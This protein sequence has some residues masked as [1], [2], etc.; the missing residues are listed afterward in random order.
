MTYIRK[1]WGLIITMLMVMVMTV[2]SVMPLMADET[3]EYVTREYAV[4]EFVQSAGRNNLQGS[5]LVLTLFGDADKI[6]PEY[7]DDMAKAITNGMVTGSEDRMLEPAELLKRAEALVLFER[8]ISLPVN[9]DEVGMLDGINPADVD[10]AKELLPA[11]TPEWAVNEIAL[12]VAAGL[13]DSEELAKAPLT[14]PVTAEEL[15]QLIAKSDELLNTCPVGN[16]FYGYVNNKAFR[17][18]ELT[19]GTTIDA[20]HGAVFQ[21]IDSWSPAVD[22]MNDINEKENAYLYALLEGLI[23]YEDGTPEQRLHDLLLCFEENVLI[24]DADK[25]Q[26][27]AWRNSI[28][29][30]ADVQELMDTAAAIADETGY[31]PL[32]TVFYDFD[33]ETNIVIPVMTFF[34]DRAGGLINYRSF[35]R[36]KATSYYKRLLTGYAQAAAIPVTD[37]DIDRF[38]ELEK[39]F[40]SQANYFDAIKSSMT[41]YSMLGVDVDIEAELALILEEHPELDENGELKESTAVFLLPEEADSFATAVKPASVLNSMGFHDY[42]KV[43]LLYGDVMAEADNLLTE[44]NLNALKFGTILSL[45]YDMYAY[46][47]PEEAEWLTALSALIMDIKGATSA[48]SEDML[49]PLPSDTESDLSGFSSGDSSG[50]DD[51]ADM[52]ETEEERDIFTDGTLTEVKDILPDDIGIIYASRIKDESVYDDIMDIIADIATAYVNRFNKNE[53]MSDKTAAEAKGKIGNMIVV[54]GYP[55]NYTFPVIL[56]PEDGG[57]VYSNT[58]SASKNS[59]EVLIRQCSEREF[60]RTQ[61]YYP[62]DTINACYLAAINSINVFAGILNPPFYDTEVSYAANLGAIGAVIGHEIGH[63]FDT[64]GSQYDEKG[65]LR[66][67]WTPEDKEYYDGLVE[68]FVEYY[69][70][71]DIVDGIVQDST[72]T[73]TENMADFAGLRVVLDI[74]EGNPE[75]QREALMSYAS[76][77]AKLG[78]TEYLTQN[79][80]DVH[81]SNNVRVDATIASMDEFYELFDVKEGDTMYVAPEDRLKLW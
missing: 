61:M 47:D 36:E 76:M 73:I 23:P 37:D 19:S 78:T 8:T 75:A 34:P 53:W 59:L 4:S 62:P 50:D 22:I 17:N 30:A 77:W 29:N 13:T 68:K 7:S 45:S 21:Q 71:F 15:R 43:G 41:F 35:T 79:M 27:Q 69:Q 80:G 65:L 33:P 18:A 10:A 52:T 26:V 38:I 46:F 56:A 14:E 39:A 44:E 5:V 74:L 64:T 1:S 57:S 63:A 58:I 28:L 48:F 66:D 9:G 11:D 24:T 20:R 72:I 40:N 16:S 32:F 81:S 70:K 25:A 49:S 42:Y 3:E 60:V 2:S 12:L 51:Y 55:D 6:S 67:W 31:N 54:V